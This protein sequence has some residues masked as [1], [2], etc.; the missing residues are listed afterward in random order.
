MV[1]GARLPLALSFD[2]L[3]HLIKVELVGQTKMN[4]YTCHGKN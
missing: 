1:T 3:S 4:C 2:H